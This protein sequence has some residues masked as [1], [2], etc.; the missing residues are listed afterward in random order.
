MTLRNTELQVISGSM[1][2]GPM[3]YGSRAGE[4]T[5]RIDL[6]SSENNAVKVGE[7]EGR[8]DGWGWK[9]KLRS[10]FARLRIGGHDPLS[11]DQIE[12][13]YNLVEL[14]SPRFVDVEVDSDYINSKPPRV[15]QNFADSFCVFVPM[16]K[17]FDDDAFQ[18]FAERSS[19]YGDTSFVFNVRSYNDDDKIEDISNEYKIYDSDIWLY[20]TGRSVNGISDSMDKCVKISKGNMW[21]VSPRM[22]FMIDYE[23]DDE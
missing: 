2:Y 5:V 20:P 17:E 4:P 16:D 10:G 3:P 22:D 15:M 23:E 14:L 12:P 7:I 11:D 21:N 9:D 8:M 1:E 19:N 6:S 13:L 18:Y